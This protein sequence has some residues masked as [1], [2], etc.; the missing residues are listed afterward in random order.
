MK[1][2]ITDLALKRLFDNNP[3]IAQRE[4]N[5]FLCVEGEDRKCKIVQYP[6]ECFDKDYV[7]GTN[8]LEVKNM[9][10]IELIPFFFLDKKAFMFCTTEE[11]T[12]LKKKYRDAVMVAFREKLKFL[13][14]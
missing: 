2:H 5:A 6:Y 1:L 4:R 10:G 14:S 13:D 8:L 12:E 7:T 3:E 11:V 9:F